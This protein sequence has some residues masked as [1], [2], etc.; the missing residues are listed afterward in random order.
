MKKVAAIGF[1]LFSLVKAALCQVSTDE[2]LATHY[3]QNKE[4]DKAIPYYE[5]IYSKHPTGNNYHNYL[6]CLVQ[7]KDYKDAE[8]TIKKQIH[9]DDNNLGLW[10]DLGSLYQMQG[11]DK[12]AKDAFEKG[13]HN[14]TA[15]RNQ[16][17]ALGQGFLDIKQYD[18][19]LETYKKGKSLMKDQYPFLFETGAVYKAMGNIVAMTDSYLDALVIS[20]SYI[21]SVQDALQLNVADNS[22]DAQNAIIKKELLKYSQ[23]NSDNE[24]FAEL[25]IWLMIQEK[26]YANALV[27]VKAMDRR[28]H[29]MGYRVLNL[30]RTCAYN[31]SYDVAIQAYQYVVDLGNKN[32]YYMQAKSELLNTMYQKL[33]SG[34]IY[35]HQ[36]LLE[37]QN[38]YK[39][40]LGELGENAG[41]VTLIQNLAYLDAF[42][43]DEADTSIDIL[44]RAIAFPNLAPNARARCQMELADALVA[45]NRVWEASLTYSKVQDAFLQDPI[46]EEARLKNATIYFYTGNFAWA[47]A[48]LDI[49]K[50][51]TSKPTANDAMSLSLTISDNTQDSN[52]E[53]PLRLF[54]RAMLSDFQN[55]EDSASI[56]LDSIENLSAASHSLKEQV[57]MMHAAIAMKKADYAATA[58]YY[59]EETKNYGD[60]LLPDKA[61]YMLAQLQEKKLKNPDKAA[62]LY[63]QIILNYPGSFYVEDA[64]E[65]YRHLSKTDAAPV[66]PVN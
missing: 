3:Y 20:P 58:K 19:A 14:L 31:E 24:I 43:L 48:Q 62:D 21:Q 5:K 13:I 66:A 10:I 11:E 54:A 46:G 40:A 28:K 27:Q 57:I 52:A 30:A 9:Y 51:A 29:E 7:T 50:A 59:E 37:L 44:T 55:Q 8:K 36:D 4:Y 63:K 23:H 49:L 64:R 38:K 2:Q 65:R 18:Y 1:I 6:E 16:V 22:D 25:L 56:L 34:G 33:V 45:D 61:L 47:K 15:D 35:S 39:Q 42:Y 17:L 12:Q 32:D 26:D 41:T 53:Q 60:G